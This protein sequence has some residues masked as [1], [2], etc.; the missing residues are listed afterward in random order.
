[1]L[2]VLSGE[3]SVAEAARKGRCRVAGLEDECRGPVGPVE[4]VE[5]IRIDEGNGDLGVLRTARHS[6]TDVAMLASPSPGRS[7]GQGAVACSFA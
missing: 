3:I 1:M 4:D 2:R 7:A 6:R 5:V